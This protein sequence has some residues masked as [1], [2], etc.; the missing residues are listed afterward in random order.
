MT[1]FYAGWEQVPWF[2]ASRTQLRTADLPREPV[3]PAGAQVRAYHRGRRAVVA[4]Y[5]V[6]SSRPTAASARQLEAAADRRTRETRVCGGAAPGATVLSSS[7]TGRR[8]AR[9]AG[10][11]GTLL[12]FRLRWVSGVN[13]LLCGRRGC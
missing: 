10:G 4:L 12:L 6:E 9:C 3:G 1:V 11:C 5:R 7:A 2:M 13:N 8:C